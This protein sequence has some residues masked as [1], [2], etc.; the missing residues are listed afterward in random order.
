LLDAMIGDGT[1]FISG[2]ETV[3]SWKIFTPVLENWPEQGTVGIESYAAGS[4]GPDSADAL[5]RTARHTW[6]RP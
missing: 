6:R 3:E 4:W 2:D 1:L 5:L